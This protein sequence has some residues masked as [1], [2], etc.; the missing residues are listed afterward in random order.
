M[1]NQTKPIVALGCGA[2]LLAVMPCQTTQA[3]LLDISGTSILADLNGTG[4]ASPPEALTISWSVIEDVSD[5]YTYTYYINNPAHD[6]VL[7]DD[8]PEIVGVFGVSFNILNPHAVV[9]GP[10][11]ADGSFYAPGFG[12]SWNYSSP[13]NVP[14][15]STSGPLTFESDLPPSPG[16]ASASD[17]NPPSPWASSPNGQQV[18]VPGT[19]NFS[20]PDS[21]NTMAL[22]AGVLLLLPF[23]F[24]MRKKTSLALA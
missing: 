12:V 11:G 21:M 4:T 14:A 5:V 13:D 3:A 17:A 15:G 9:G 24:A 20:V 10:S 8:L 22:L 1:K 18:P 7:S 6:V 23:E 2:I 16:D 19:G